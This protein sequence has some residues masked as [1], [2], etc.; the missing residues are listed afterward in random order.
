MPYGTVYILLYF[1]FPQKKFYTKLY[2][3]LEQAEVIQCS[4][5][6]HCAVCIYGAYLK[7]LLPELSFS[8]CWSRRRKSL[9]TRLE[10]PNTTLILC[11]LLYSRF[12]YMLH[13]TCSLYFKY[14]QQSLTK[15]LAYLPTFAI[16][17]SS[18]P[19]PPPPP[20]PIQC[21]FSWWCHHYMF[22]ALSV[23]GGGRG[24]PIISND[25]ISQKYLVSAFLLHVHLLIYLLNNSLTGSRR[26]K[27]VGRRTSE[28]AW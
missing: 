22:T 25:V 11:Y 9:G 19:S 2:L 3:S 10:L 17:V 4:I 24:F 28:F 1:E 8:D 5:R 16:S 27:T 20:S 21:W 7:W 26:W 12:S 15:V 18:S 23:M 14:K 13:V 6:F